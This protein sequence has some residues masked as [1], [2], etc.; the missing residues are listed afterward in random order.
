MSITRI[1]NLKILQSSGGFTIVEVLVATVIF[2][3]AALGT[4]STIASIRKPAAVSERKLQGA[5]YAKQILEDLRPQVDA[6]NWNPAT[7]QYSSG[8]LTMGTHLLSTTTIN[9]TP[10]IS[11]YV[12]STVAG[13]PNLFQVQVMVN[14]T[15]I[16]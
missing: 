15:E 11:S 5:Y 16:P 3:I 1:K 13:T 9:G 2:T 8:D 7:G 10:Y 4:F 6:R 12:V 14:W